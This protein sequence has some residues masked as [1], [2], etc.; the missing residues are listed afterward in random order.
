MGSSQHD[1]V[2]RKYEVGEATIFPTLADLDGVSS[3]G[4]A[5]EHDLEAVYYDTAELD[6]A[7]HG[8]TLRR[9]TGGHDAGWHLKLPKVG[10]TRTELHRPLGRATTTV[11]EQ[12]LGHV[13]PLVRGRRL[14]PVAR[15][16]TR[17]LEHTVL[18]AGGVALAQVC[19]DHVHAERLHGP[20]LVRD[21]R[22]WEVELV[23]GDPA[24]LDLVERRL[25]A[26]GATPASVASKLAR[27]LGD[28]V[29]AAQ[30]VRRRPTRKELSR[31]S[32][33]QLV[34]THLADQ[35]AELHTQDTRLRADEPGS[36]HKLRIAARR[37]RSALKSC[38][39][40][41]QPGAADPIGE[42]LRWLGQSL[43]AARDAQVLRERLDDLIGSEPAELVLGPVRTRIDDEL[44]SAYLAGRAEALAAL[45]SDRYYRLLDSLDALL[46]ST[47]LTAEADAPA[48]EVLPRLL[49]RD[50]KRLRAAV[51]RI[52]D[53]GDPPHR[54]AALH[55]ARKKAKRMRYGAE[56]AI[57]VFGKRAKRLAA[58]SKSVQEALGQHQDTVVARARLREYGVQA[59]LNGENGF[60]FGRLHALEQARADQAERDFESAWHALPVKRV[61]RWIR[62]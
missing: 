60:T 4:Q 54:D 41:L 34:R 30:P 59:H 22:E 50:A 26:A 61:D 48:R 53:S 56:S 31:G 8:T 46:E 29:P 25:L 28:A 35:V 3:M 6:L 36:V 58:A 55:E 37:L 5:V 47:P 11:P 16:R 52:P 27:S 15:V 40:L 7:R 33:A 14:V 23:D 21:W 42:E 62:R 13:R 12:L 24:L 49:R 51:D 1:E 19:D 32:A 57:P 17:R 38:Q 43:A 45:D 39:P 10:D 44:S 9:R 18:G 20:S 2:E